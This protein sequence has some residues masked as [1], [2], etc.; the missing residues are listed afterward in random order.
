MIKIDTH[1]HPNFFFRLPENLWTKRQSAKIWWEIQKRDLDAIIVTE[2]VFKRPALSYKILEANR[3]AEAKT[4]L[5]PW[6]EALSKEWIDMLIFSKDTHVYTC[7]EIM[8]PQK[9]TFDQLV[10]YIN[11]DPKLQ[12]IVTHPFILSDTGVVKHFPEEKV[13][14]SAKK[15]GFIEKQNAAF[16]TMRQ[17]L[18]KS[19]FKN[20]RITK[21]MIEK[22]EKIE[23]VPEKY[24]AKDTVVVW[25][26]D[27]HNPYDLG[28]YTVLQIQNKNKEQLR[29]SLLDPSIER[30]FHI[31]TDR[32]NVWWYMLR[33][34]VIIFW[35]RILK[36]SWLY[37]IDSTYFK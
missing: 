32:V 18:E 29:E 15:L 1:F 9:L 34:S 7:Q 24:Y 36:T 5:I 17:K 8:T 23:N 10:E 13:L 11:N 28:D 12:W 25:W 22:F 3:P 6:V 27:A 35:E 30:S 2:H 19:I 4:Y 14:E 31:T 21:K 37:K 16:I 26:S 33:N 20:L